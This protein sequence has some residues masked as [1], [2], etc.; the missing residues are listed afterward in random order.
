MKL[1]L[2]RVLLV[3]VQVVYDLLFGLLTRVNQ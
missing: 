3:N 2:Q 1:F